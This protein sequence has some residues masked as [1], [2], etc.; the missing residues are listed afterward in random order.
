M[1][2]TRPAEFVALTST[3]MLVI[4][5]IRTTNVPLLLT[6]GSCANYR[7]QSRFR[8]G[9][10]GGSP[11]AAQ[12]SE[13]VQWVDTQDR[14]LLRRALTRRGFLG[15]IAATAATAILA[16]CGGSKATD[17]PKP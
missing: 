9:H 8:R 15:G 14:D 1:G 6:S 4:L 11:Q 2:R 16:A 7:V 3:K 10:P 12:V 17:T 5:G 13:G